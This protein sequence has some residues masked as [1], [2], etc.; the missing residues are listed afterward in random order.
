[1]TMKGKGTTVI[2]YMLLYYVTTC[3]HISHCVVTVSRV[4][5]HVNII[6]SHICVIMC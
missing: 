4:T 1:M 5:A 6:L 3:A 2:H